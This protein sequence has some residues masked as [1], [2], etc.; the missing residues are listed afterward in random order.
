VDDV[1]K[2][3]TMELKE[4]GSLIAVIGVTYP[5]LGGSEYLFKLFG[6]E[7]GEI[8]RPRPASELRNATFILKAIRLGLLNAVHDISVGGLAVALAEMAVLGNLGVEVSIDSVYAR[9]VQRVDELLFSETQAR[10]VV[11]VKSDRVE[12]L[13][14]LAQKL[15][16]RMSVVGRVLDKPI[17]TLSKSS[18]TILS[19]DLDLLKDAYNSLERAI[20]GGA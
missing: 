18:K 20:E 8:P 6:V 16:V 17:F 1:S 12:E 13:K 2:A 9:G 15:G 14:K 11:E 5:E 3:M 10:Y 4:S 19:V 7:E